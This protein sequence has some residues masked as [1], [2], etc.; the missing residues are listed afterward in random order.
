M[1]MYKASAVI[2]KKYYEFD[3]DAPIAAGHGFV[4]EGEYYGVVSV[5]QDAANGC[6][7]MILT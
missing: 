6:Q 2:D 4:F 1:Q 7:C 3:L 5:I